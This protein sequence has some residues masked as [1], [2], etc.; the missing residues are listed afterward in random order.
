VWILLGA[1]LSQQGGEELPLL[2]GSESRVL[3]GCDGTETFGYC[4]WHSRGCHSTL[5][6]PLKVSEMGPACGR[7][8]LLSGWCVF[9]D[10]V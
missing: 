9:E 7:A 3:R 5:L 2:L 8:L 6:S 1:K 4:L 10:G